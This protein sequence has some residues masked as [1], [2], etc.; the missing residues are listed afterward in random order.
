MQLNGICIK[1]INE[2]EINKCIKTAE[3]ICTLAEQA[4]RDG[5]LALEDGIPGL[6]SF[7]LKKGIELVCDGVDEESVRAFLSRLIIAGGYEGGD[8][9]IR[10]LT[11]EGVMGIHA[12]MNPRMLKSSLYSFLG[13]ENLK[14]LEN[15]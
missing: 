1:D 3:E 5:I 4:R 12:G 8:L 9:L 15:Q 11:V 6:S 13:E 14:K 10:L 2:E 7:L